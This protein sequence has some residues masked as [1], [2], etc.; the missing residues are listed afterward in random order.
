M[1]A[2]WL[3]GCNSKTDADSGSGTDTDIAVTTDT[4]AMTENDKIEA[5]INEAMT[6][7]RY[8]DKSY[9]YDMELD[10]YKDQNSFDEYLKHGRILNA[11]A[12]TLEYVKV[13]SAEFFGDDSAVATV[14]VHFKGMTG[15]ES[16]IE[17]PGTVFYWRNGKWIK[18]TVSSM[19]D[20]LLYEAIQE[21][22]RRQARS[23][24][25]K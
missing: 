21:E 23:E 6:R 18:P 24:S 3:V 14:A 2:G 13:L 7:L 10:Y 22:A 25:G 15:K 9:L 16:V 11:N 20:Q 17:Q 19:K 5:V 12:D 1:L 4:S 8:H